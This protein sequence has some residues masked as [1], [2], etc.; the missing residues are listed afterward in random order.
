MKEKKEEEEKGKIAI[1]TKKYFQ[2]DKAKK[3]RN[4]ETVN[5]NKTLKTELLSYYKTLKVFKVLSPEEIEAI[6]IFK[7]E[8]CSFKSLHKLMM[9]EGIKNKSI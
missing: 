8:V 5:L 4:L 6:S 3:G 7:N 9:M 1:S 2:V